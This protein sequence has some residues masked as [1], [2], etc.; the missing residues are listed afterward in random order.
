MKGNDDK[1]WTKNGMVAI[2]VGGVAP[3]Q[4]SAA[5]DQDARA[6]RSY[7]RKEGTGQLRIGPA[8]PAD[9]EVLK[10]EILLVATKIFHLNK[11][12]F[13]KARHTSVI[14]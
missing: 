12:K 2:L 14:V 5:P 6:G 4:P 10:L 9:L 8:G 7:I 1:R 13:G 3:H 11:E